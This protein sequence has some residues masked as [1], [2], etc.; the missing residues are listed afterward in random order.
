M[1]DSWNDPKIIRY[2]EKIIDV[3]DSTDVLFKGNIVIRYD[4]FGEWPPLEPF[5]I[6]FI[7]GFNIMPS[8]GNSELIA[9]VEVCSDDFTRMQSLIDKETTFWRADVKVF[10]SPAFVSVLVH[11]WTDVYDDLR[12]GTLM[13]GAQRFNYVI[14]DAISLMTEG[15]CSGLSDRGI[16]FDLVWSE[17]MRSGPTARDIEL[18]GAGDLVIPCFAERKIP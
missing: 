8:N 4:Y 1:S 11:D 6:G 3:E 2:V 7:S 17:I 16:C 15:L 12:G 9:L 5:Y 14:M 13:A 10:G 18:G